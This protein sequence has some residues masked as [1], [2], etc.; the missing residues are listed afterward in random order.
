M[1]ALPGYN[2]G[3]ADKNDTIFYISNGLIPKR[4]SGYDW[5]NVVPGNTMK[6]L[7]QDTYAIEELPQV[8]QPESGYFYNAN[9]SPFI[10]SAKNDNPDDKLFAKEMGFEDF[11]NNRSIRIKQ[12]I[13]SKDKISYQ[14]F[15]RIKYDHSYP[16]PYHF[17]WMNIDYLDLIKPE[18]YPEI[19]KLISRVQNWDRK[20]VAN[21]LG[22]GTFA[23]LYDK[24]CLLYTSD[25]ADE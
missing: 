1:K 18:D 3:Y 7:W 20:A 16:K 21:S 8:I 4:Q 22:A 5:E 11:E 19:E 15:K 25:A 10:S 9:H 24:F 2:I 17:S 13:D 12:L 6:T 14:D 23:C